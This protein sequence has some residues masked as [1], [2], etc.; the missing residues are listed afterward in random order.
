MDCISEAFTGQGQAV[1]G[2]EN[3]KQVSAYGPLLSTFLEKYGASPDDFSRVVALCKDG[4]NVVLTPDVLEGV[5][6]SIAQGTEPLD[7]AHQPM[8]LIVPSEESGKW[9]YGV[10]ALVFE[11]RK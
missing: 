2:Q 5:V 7:E 8:R 3:L 11:G 4:Y 9:A 10:T 6:M 1:G